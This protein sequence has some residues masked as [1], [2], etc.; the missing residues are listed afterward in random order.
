MV[1][2][3]IAEKG[4]AE[5]IAAFQ[6]ARQLTER[7]IELRLVGDG[8]ALR[9]LIDS[10]RPE[11]LDCVEEVGYVPDAAPEIARCAVG[12]LPTYYAAESLPCS[13]VE[14][15]ASGCPVIATGIAGIPEMLASPAGSAGIIVPLDSM[16]GRADVRE[17]AKAMA[18]LADDPALH[19]S[20]AE[21]AL[22]AARKFD[23]DTCVE[24]YEQVFA[25][26]LGDVHRL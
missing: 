10:L 22:L 23:L 14:Y 6:Q 18:A 24:S 7:R 1:A 17:L 16:T 12:L 21:R 15:L 26:R 3:G 13:I 25:E 4:W 9:E 20:L 19:R 5:A 2:R 8:P 11:D